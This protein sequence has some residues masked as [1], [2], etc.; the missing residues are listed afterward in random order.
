MNSC[1]RRKLTFWVSAFHTS[2]HVTRDCLAQI[3]IQVAT[4]LSRRLGINTT[5]LATVFHSQLFHR[6]RDPS[7]HT[8]SEDTG[9]SRLG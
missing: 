5:H 1:A 4:A 8:S 6:D 9:A 2:L 7:P 3:I